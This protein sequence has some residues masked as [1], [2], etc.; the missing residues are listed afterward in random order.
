MNHRPT[1][2]TSIA[3][4][5]S[6]SENFPYRQHQDRTPDDHRPR[7]HQR[8]RPVCH[9]HCD[10]Y[11]EYTRCH[12]GNLRVA[13]EAKRTEW[14][15]ACPNNAR[16]V[17]V[18]LPYSRGMEDLPATSRF[19]TSLRA[20]LTWSTACQVEVLLRE[21]NLHPGGEICWRSKIVE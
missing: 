17:R 15:A 16:K 9:E 13:A 12:L 21:M 11:R 10:G 8:R 2:I 5:V 6:N 20:A 4:E 7:Q 3:N 1:V 18:R 14:I 19:V